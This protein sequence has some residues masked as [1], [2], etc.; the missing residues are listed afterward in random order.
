MASSLYAVNSRPTVCCLHKTQKEPEAEFLTELRNSIL[1]TVDANKDDRIELG[2]FAQ[3]VYSNYY[4][5]NICTAMHYNVYHAT[6]LYI[7]T[8]LHNRRTTVKNGR[9]DVE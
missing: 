8:L 7:H 9:H 6:L 2:E 5:L 3:Y 4:S 1:E